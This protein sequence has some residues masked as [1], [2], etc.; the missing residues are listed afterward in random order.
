MK[1]ETQTNDRRR[2]EVADILASTLLAMQ[3]QQHRARN[4]AR[5]ST[6]RRETLEEPTHGAEEE[7]R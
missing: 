2:R 5:R 3:A 6:Q 7:T 1:H 4:S